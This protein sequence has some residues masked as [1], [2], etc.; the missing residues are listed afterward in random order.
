MFSSRYARATK[1]GLRLAIMHFCTKGVVRKL[2]PRWPPVAA[3]LDSRWSSVRGSSQQSAAGCRRRL[4]RPAPS[5][6]GGRGTGVDEHF[7]PAL[8]VPRFPGSPGVG[9]MFATSA[10]A[11]ECPQGVV[12]PPSAPLARRGESQRRRTGHLLTFRT[13]VGLVV[14]SASRRCG[15]TVT[16]DLTGCV[17]TGATV[18]EVEAEIREAIAIHVEGLREDGLPI[19]A[20]SS[21]VGYVEIAA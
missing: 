14:P 2:S 16:L 6:L 17:A 21:R 8:P 12:F 13:P 15:S 4:G 5:P 7:G 1:A 9:E 19:P 20:P 3:R 11:S 10:G 18:P